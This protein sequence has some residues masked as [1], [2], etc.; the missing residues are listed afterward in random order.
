M[1]CGAQ[2][3]GE[4]PHKLTAM[5]SVLALLL[6]CAPFTIAAIGAFPIWDDASVW[7]LIQER[8]LSAIVAS[9][10]D[11][12]VMGHLWSLLAISENSF[13][14]AAFVAQ[15][16]LWPAL[17][18]LSALVWSHYFP[19]LR[20]FAWVVGCVAVAPFATKVQMVTANIALASFLSVALGYAAL[21]L[22]VRVIT[23]DDRW[24]RARFAAGLSL[25][26]SA[27]LVQEYALSV[28]M[29]MLVLFGATARFW[30]DRETRRRAFRV[31][32]AS[33]LTAVVAYLIY[34]LLADRDV[35]A[36]VH[37]SYA[38][39]LGPLYFLSLPF[40]LVS[41]LWWGIGGGVANSLS[42]VSF[43]SRLD[44]FAAAYGVVVALLLVYGC[45]S[46][47]PATNESARP[48]DV[49]TA[50]LFAL[51]LIAGITPMVLMGRVPW[52]PNDGMS[53]R[54][55]LPVLPLAAALIVFASVALVRARFWAVPVLLLGFAAGHAAFSDAWSAVQERRMMSALGEALQPYVSSGPGYTVAVIPLP[56]RSLGPRRQWELTA[57]VAANWPA[58]LRQR[59]WAYRFGGGL[60]LYSDEEA[61]RVFGPRG[62]CRRPQE[63]DR[64]VRLVVR[65]GHLDRLL[66]AEPHSDGSISIEPY[67]IREREQSNTAATPETEKT[68][69]GHPFD[70]RFF[71]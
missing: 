28:V 18:L 44:I 9:H 46:H 3:P 53:S 15:A 70:R 57:R 5:S 6:I 42:Q 40:R 66:W 71:G 32:G 39:K 36:D 63:I 19:T 10:R 34:F 52:D 25:L 64:E 31:I 65:R 13:W 33:T 16:L 26:A 23:A 62:S 12:P 69:P 22:F 17:G 61:G 68:T 1:R 54:F 51:A 67:C 41:V 24:S 58:A 4:T 29:V 30:G 11:R 43:V 60:P 2:S 8:G 47:G 37:P 35:R 50:L 20:R 55:G 56:E 59:F 48:K 27:I 38:I 14:G 45:H 49:A 21:V 7:L